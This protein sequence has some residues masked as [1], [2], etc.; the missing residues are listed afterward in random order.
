MGRRPSLLSN[1]TETSASPSGLRFSFP[2]KITSSIFPERR[3]LLLCSPSTQRKASIKFDLP[4]PF[5]PT[6]AVMPP[7]ND[8]VVGSANVLK[9]KH[10]ICLSFIR[11]PLPG[12]REA[13]AVP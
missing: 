6:I 5:G 11:Q 4:D 8:N 3:L 10:L 7:P 13:L 1:V 9:P 2:A 12:A